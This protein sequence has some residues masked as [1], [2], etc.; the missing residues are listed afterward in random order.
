D[1]PV[2]EVREG[3]ILADGKIDDQAF[4]APILRYQGEAMVFRDTRIARVRRLAI[5]GDRA[6]FALQRADERHRQFRAAGA[7]QARNAED[8]AVAD[9]EIDALQRGAAKPAYFQQR[10]AD[11]DRFFGIELRNIASH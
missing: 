5:D 10:A 6:A 4:L 7:D 2:R 9:G 11:R 1:G 3:E 8:L